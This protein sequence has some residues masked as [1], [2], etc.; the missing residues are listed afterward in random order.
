MV[1]GVDSSVKSFWLNFW[2]FHKLFH[3]GQFIQHTCSSLSP[4]EKIVK[5]LCSYQIAVRIEIINDKLLID[6]TV[7]HKGSTRVS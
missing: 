5:T 6:Y 1:K 4:S 3:P 2:D 7:R